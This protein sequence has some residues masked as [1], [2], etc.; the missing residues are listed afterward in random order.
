MQSFDASLFPKCPNCGKPELP[1]GLMI[2]SFSPGAP[3]FFCDGQ[4]NCMSIRCTGCG[5][6]V[7]PLYHS[8]HECGR[9]RALCDLREVKSQPLQVEDVLAEAERILNRGAK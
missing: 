2:L 1:P 6:I 5:H 8:Y 3:R 4:G 7:N 9:L